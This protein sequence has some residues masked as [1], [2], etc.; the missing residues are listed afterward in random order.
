MKKVF[1]GIVSLALMS[2][3]SACSESDK[4][5]DVVEEVIEEIVEEEVEDKGIYGIYS[6]LP[7]ESTLTWTGRLAGDED[8][9]SH[10]GTVYLANGRLTVNNDK[11]EGGVVVDLN[12][13]VN[14]DLTEEEDKEMLISQLSSDNF[15]NIGR[16]DNVKVIIEAGSLEEAKVTLFMMGGDL[17]LTLPL[18]A[19]FNRQTGR[20]TGSFDVDFSSFEIPGMQ[21]SGSKDFVSPIISFELDVNFEIE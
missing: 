6:M 3:V 7:E 15:F 14:E 11:Y 17:E 5:A 9:K 10:T 8:A 16:Y 13:I 4:A 2:V 1:Y 19:E 18:Q 20:I 21:K 12:K